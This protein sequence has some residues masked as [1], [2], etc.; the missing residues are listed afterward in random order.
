M[1]IGGLSVGEPKEDM[2][3]I[4]AL[5]E[6]GMRVDCTIQEGTV[7]VAQGDTSLQLTPEILKRGSGG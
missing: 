3:R 6:R 5:A 4:L 7:W 1:A 2:K